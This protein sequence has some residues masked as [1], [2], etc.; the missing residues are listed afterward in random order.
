MRLDFNVLWVDDQP[1]VVEAQVLAIQRKMADEGFAFMPRLCNSMAEVRGALSS[2]LFT[3]EIDLIL[4]DW[5]LGGGVE[6]QEAI[7]EIRDTVHYKDVVFYSAKST[8][9]LRKAAFEKGLEG[10]YCAS[11]EHLVEEVLGVFESLVKKVL[12]LDHTRGIVMGAT[13]DI[14]YVV[15]QC[16]ETVAAQLDG[17]ANEKLLE[18]ALGYVAKRLQ[19]STKQSKALENATTLGEFF[20]AHMVF[21]SNDRMRFFR[22]LLK[23]FKQAIHDEY[24]KDL[25]QYQNHVVPG[26]NRLGHMVLIPAGKPNAVV[27]IEGKQVSLEETRK[28]RRLILDLRTKFRQLLAALQPLAS[29]TES[30]TPSS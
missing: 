22:K 13:S 18:E 11:R 30:E 29:T 4:V 20:E 9:D 14:D 7:A 28:L 21:T 16:L 27:D 10:V 26:R 2:G 6:G 3:D 1:N 12:D 15:N 25:I 17:A 23:G 19:E 8:V 5:D 24:D